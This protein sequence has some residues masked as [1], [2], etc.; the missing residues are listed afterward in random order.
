MK[1][2]GSF[3]SYNTSVE[4]ASDVDNDYGHSPHFRLAVFC[5]VLSFP[6]CIVM[7]LRH[8]IV[9]DVTSTGVPCLY[10]KEMIGVRKMVDFAK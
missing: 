2:I 9:E 3:I 10:G 4:L 1:T 7:Y 8:H 6:F 5:F